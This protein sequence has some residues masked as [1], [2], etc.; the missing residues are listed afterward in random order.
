MHRGF[1][2]SALILLIS[3]AA[4]CIRIPHLADRPMHNDEGVNASKF[5]EVYEHGTFRYDPSQ[6]HGPAFWFL[7]LPVAWCSGEHAWIDLT[8]AN[9]RLV[10][11]I[12][13]VGVVLTLLLLRQAMGFAAAAWAG[14]FVAFSPAMVYYSRD[15]IHEMTLVLFTALAIAAGWKWSQQGRWPW[16]ICCGASLGFMHA[17]KE[18][19]FVIGAAMFCGLFLS[20]AW[21]RYGERERVRFRPWLRKRHVLAAILTSILISVLFYSS[22]F[23]D[24]S[25]LKSAALFFQTYAS[26]A[27]GQIGHVQPAGYYAKLL[28]Y[29]KI[30]SGPRWSEGLIVGLALI[31]TIAVLFFK[32]L[33]E[34]HAPFQRFIVFYTFS[35]FVAFSLI[36]YKTPW[37]VLCPLHGMA[38]LAGI[39]AAAIMRAVR[40]AALKLV[41]GSLILAGVYQLGSQACL[42]ISPRYAA[43]LRNP[44]VYGQTTGDALRLVTLLESLAQ[45]SPDGHS[46]GIQLGTSES[47]W[48]LPWYL[49]G[50]SRVYLYDTTPPAAAAPVVIVSADLNENLD[51]RVK[52]PSKYESVI[53]GLRPGYVLN[54]YVRKDL[55]AAYLASRE[56][57]RAAGGPR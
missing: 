14:L 28:L 6:Y 56:R 33:D 30:G 45:A 51:P 46:L 53:R 4:L 57:S 47:Y 12:C 35:L 10:P 9:Y 31:G 25:G 54:V 3:I 22:F 23:R 26:R 8:E 17:T 48:P 52:D 32:P 29:Q 27:S 21:A 43:D 55:W 20:F 19:S 18:T 37:N 15:Y 38:L 40:P 5:Q 2:Y 49:R 13:G 50:F 42:A 39:G 24:F 41:A 16:A 11:V 1:L 36:S 44:Y 34:K 7:T